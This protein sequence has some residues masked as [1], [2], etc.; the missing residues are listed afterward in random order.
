MQNAAKYIIDDQGLDN[1][2]YS[3]MVFGSQ[4]STVVDFNQRINSVDTLKRY[5]ELASLPSGGPDLKKA[6]DESKRV[7]DNSGRPDARK[8]LVVIVDKRSTNSPDDIMSA[9]VP[10]DKN[11]VRVIPVLVGNDVYPTEM[12]KVTP[13]KLGIVK[14]NKDVEPE[15]L[16]KV[17]LDRVLRGKFM[18]MFI[19]TREGRVGH[20]S[21]I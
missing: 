11:G 8:V 10:L 18:M 21:R 4:P 17:I 9:A 15:I 6:L 5:I 13:D 3:F 20:S 16:G 2:R 1:I 12:E 14:V 7:F 19:L